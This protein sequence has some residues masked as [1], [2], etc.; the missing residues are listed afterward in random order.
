MTSGAA[1]SVWIDRRCE[2]PAQLGEGV[3][4]Q[5]LHLILAAAHQASHLCKGALLI[6]AVAEL[7]HH[8]LWRR[9]VLELAVNPVVVVVDERLVIIRHGI[10]QGHIAITAGELLIERHRAAAVLNRHG[11]EQSL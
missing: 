4:L 3:T 2:M 7:D 10:Q 8:Q 11:V 1:A 5:A 6:F 9:E